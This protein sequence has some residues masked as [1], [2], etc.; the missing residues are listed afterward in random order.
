MQHIASPSFSFFFILQKGIRHF[1]VLQGFKSGFRELK[2]ELAYAGAPLRVTRR[3]QRAARLPPPLARRAT[4]KASRRARGGF[5]PRRQAV[6]R[7]TEPGKA[8]REEKPTARP[9]RPRMHGYALMAGFVARREPDGE[10]AAWRAGV[11]A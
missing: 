9:D 11:V 4:R 5:L 8:P 7:K 1:L 6:A 10:L 3:E 2:G